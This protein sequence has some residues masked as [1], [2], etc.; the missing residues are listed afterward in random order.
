MHTIYLQKYE[1]SSAYGLH[2]C[3]I[4][5][6]ISMQG[7]T[8]KSTSLLLALASPLSVSLNSQL[9]KSL[10]QQPP[11]HYFTIQRETIKQLSGLSRDTET[12]KRCDG[13]Q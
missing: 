1:G 5:V 12:M 13:D 2:D 9:F 3:F 4:V 10:F 11:T 8:M 6:V 7:V